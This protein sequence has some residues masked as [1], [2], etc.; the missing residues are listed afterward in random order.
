MV[1]KSSY[2][3]YFHKFDG[4]CPLER[5]FNSVM[6]RMQAMRTIC[7]PLMI[8]TEDNEGKMMSDSTFADFCR[9]EIWMHSIIG[10]LTEWMETI[11]KYFTEYE[12]S[13]KYYAAARR[14]EYLREFMGVDG[15]PSE[16]LD[17]DE[18]KE[19]SITEEILDSGWLDPAKTSAL[20]VAAICACL[21]TCAQIHMPS[22]IKEYFKDDVKV[23]KLE[24]G[25]MKEVTQD[26]MDLDKASAEAN[27]D[28]DAKRILAV[29]GGVHAILRIV[30]GL[31]YNEDNTEALNTVRNVSK[32][33][34]NMDFDVL[35]DIVSKFAESEEKND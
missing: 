3:A 19:F 11:D 2:Y 25:V 23:C 6:D 16:G 7:S 33:L 31:S 32:A 9:Y 4:T 1:L 28:D 27:A 21:A 14:L 34:L 24:D 13:W 20:D 30:E 29:S 22:K 5:F 26:E 35:Y 12:G 10:R 17:D 18:Y 8:Q 15:K